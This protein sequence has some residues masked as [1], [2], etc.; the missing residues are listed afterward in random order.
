MD[1]QIIEVKN[2]KLKREYKVIIPLSAINEK[3]NERLK[4]LSKT[5]TVKGFRKGKV[6][7]EILDKT[8]GVGVLAEIAEKLINDTSAEVIKEKNLDPLTEPKLDVIKFE[9]GQDVEYSISFEAKP[10]FE[11]LDLEAIKLNR[12][13]IKTTDEIIEETTASLL[14]N[15]KSFEPLKTPRAAKKGDQLV[16]DYVGKVDNKEFNGGSANDAKLVLGSKQFIPGYEE[17]LEGAKKGDTVL[18]KVTFPADYN[19]KDLAG[20]EAEFEVNVKDILKEKKAE[21][22]DEL[23]G[24]FNCK[25]VKEFKNNITSMLESQYKEVS[26][27][28]MKKE[29]FDVIDNHYSFELPESMVKTE[30]QSLTAQYKQDL[31]NSPDSEEELTE[32]ELQELSERRVKLGIVLLEIS[33]QQNITATGEELKS[34]LIKQAQSF[35]GQ[36]KQIID[37]YKKNKAALEQ[38]KAPIIEDKVV[39][40]IIGKAQITDKDTDINEFKKVNEDIL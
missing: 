24:K 15:N 37:F 10:D 21:L 25:T 16:I 35:P 39:D 38:L 17:Q 26:K 2:E 23:L 27:T 1:K 36:E 34:A 33:K 3:K 30:L 9:P 28:K 14:E 6:P 32:K 5:T 7:M 13:N 8:H 12:Y 19:H 20:K 40:Y 29:L 11:L 18:V 4:E 22:D 31:K